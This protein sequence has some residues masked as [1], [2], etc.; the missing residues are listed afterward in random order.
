MKGYCEAC[1]REQEG[2]PDEYG[3]DVCP[4]CG[5]DLMSGFHTIAEDWDD[6]GFE[7]AFLGRD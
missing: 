1:R 4:D 5:C 2:T 3:V 7:G 6:E